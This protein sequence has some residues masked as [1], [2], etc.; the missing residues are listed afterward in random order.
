MALP[1]DSTPGTSS[2]L[3]APDH[4]RFLS[5][6]LEAVDVPAVNTRPEEAPEL[7]T[8]EHLNNENRP[9]HE[10]SSAQEAYTKGKA[11]IPPPTKAPRRRRIV[12]SYKKHRIIVWLG[13]LGIAA[14]IAIVCAVAITQTKKNGHSTS[15]SERSDERLYQ[16]SSLIS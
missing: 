16:I 15:P 5:G 7:T 4:E 13:A 6:N 3:Y 14:I 12:A 11:D 2:R 10:E 1:I 9:Q 8:V